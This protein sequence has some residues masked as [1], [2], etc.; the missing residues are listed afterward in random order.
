MTDLIEQLKRQEGFR[1]E[2][3]KC[4]AG[5]LTIG[6]GHNLEA[7]RWSRGIAEAQLH[8]DIRDARRSLV[9]HGYFGVPESE[10]VRRDCLV[11]MVF[12][13]GMGGVLGFKNMIAALRDHDYLAAS[14]HMLD[15]KWAREDTPGRANE[16]AEQMRSGEYRR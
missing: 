9:Q 14:S 3:Y 12:Q 11:N 5:K 10:P 13:M 8:D 7:E 15:S 1:A 6:Y 4:S 16:M 2:P